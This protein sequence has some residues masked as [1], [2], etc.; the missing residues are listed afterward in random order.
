MRKRLHPYKPRAY[1]PEICCHRM[2]VAI[3]ALRRVGLCLPE[4]FSQKPQQRAPQISTLKTMAGDVSAMFCSR[5]SLH[6]SLTCMLWAWS[7]SSSTGLSGISY[8]SLLIPLSC[9][10]IATRFTPISL[11]STCS[12]MPGNVLARLQSDSSN[13]ANPC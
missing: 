5:T 13:D 3:V 7:E 4:R 10:R 8:Y 12:N 9:G 6:D 11:D 1:V 2:G